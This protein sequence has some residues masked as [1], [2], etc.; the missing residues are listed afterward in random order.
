MQVD[1]EPLAAEVEEKLNLGD[2][3]QQ[4]ATEVAAVPEPST[5]EAPAVVVEPKSHS[6]ARVAAEEAPEE[7]GD[8]R[9]HLNVVFI[10]HVGTSFSP[11]QDP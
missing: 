6:P 1:V 3:G 11:S 2:E 8:N 10:G 5:P 7:D 9:Q 4:P